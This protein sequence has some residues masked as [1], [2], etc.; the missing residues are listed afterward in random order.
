M[1]RLVF[2][3]SERMLE[4]TVYP[5]R[6]LFKATTFESGDVKGVNVGKECFQELRDRLWDDAQRSERQN[7]LWWQDPYTGCRFNHKELKS[8]ER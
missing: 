8:W 2:W 3:D 5:N 6:T 1:R 4:V 7:E